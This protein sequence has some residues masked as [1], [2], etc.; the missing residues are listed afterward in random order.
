MCLLYVF[1]GSRSSDFGTFAYHDNTT[2]AHT[3]QLSRN[4]EQSVMGNTE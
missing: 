3:N 2:Q 1:F 4:D